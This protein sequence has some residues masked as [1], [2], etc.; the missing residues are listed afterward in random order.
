MLTGEKMQTHHGNLSWDRRRTEKKRRLTQS[1]AFAN[2]RVV[3]SEG[4]IVWLR[5]TPSAT[6]EMQHE[7]LFTQTPARRQCQA[8]QQ[9]S[10]SRAARIAAARGDPGTRLTRAMVEILANSLVPVFG[11]LL[12]GYAA[13]LRNVVDKKDLRALITFVMNF[14][15]PC[16][17]FTT[18]AR[19]PHPLLWGQSK[20]VLVLA[21][22]YLAIYALMYFSARRIGKLTATDSS[23]LSLTLA[24]PNAPAIGVPL[25]PAVYGN[26]SAVSVGRW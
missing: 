20:V 11:G 12:L 8:R 13:G 16:A 17:L 5:Y 22:V 26:V 4:R 7:D 21:A 15:A 3:P 9:H 19:T 23:V 1:A 10:D 2:G 14:A 6:E 24:F 25:I 18:I